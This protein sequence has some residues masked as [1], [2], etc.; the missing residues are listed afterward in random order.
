MCWVLCVGS[1]FIE[2]VL[3]CSQ[4]ITILIIHNNNCYIEECAMLC[5]NTEEGRPD[6]A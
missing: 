1:A 5:G 4:S 2:M 6:S 3:L